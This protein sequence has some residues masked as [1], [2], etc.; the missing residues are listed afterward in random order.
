MKV[1]GWAWVL[2]N[3]LGDAA[4]VLLVIDPTRPLWPVVALL[5]AT[6]ASVGVWRFLPPR[7]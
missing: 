2:A 1:P 3:G 6:V 4:L 5:V 7:G